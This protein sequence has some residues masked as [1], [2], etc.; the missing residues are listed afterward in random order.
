MEICSTENFKLV[1]FDFYRKL[2][3]DS[4]LFGVSSLI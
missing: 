3:N 2:I 4:L 1:S